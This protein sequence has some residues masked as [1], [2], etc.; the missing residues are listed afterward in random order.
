M[1]ETPTRSCPICGK[2][3][4]A[5]HTPFCSARCR[6]ADLG[7]WLGGSYRIETGER[8]DEPPPDKE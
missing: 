8:P 4:V 2:P 1:T 6:L 5:P 3:P 7:R